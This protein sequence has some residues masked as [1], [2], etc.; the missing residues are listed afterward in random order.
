M[1][2]AP[3]SWFKGGLL[4]A[5][6]ALAGAAF[7]PLAPKPAVRVDAQMRAELVDGLARQLAA[8]YV[9]PDKGARM[10]DLIRA[11][12]GSGAYDA[13][14]D[15]DQLAAAVSADLQS[16]VR[17]LHLRVRASAEPVPTS[18]GI[19]AASGPPAKPSIL[20]RWM[21][22]SGVDQVKLLGANVGYLKLSSFAA[23]EQAGPRLAAAFDKLAGSSALIIDLR[24]NQ[25]GDPD[26]VALVAS[27]LFDRP[28]HL[29]DIWWR[30]SN[31]TT[32]Y[33]T[34][35]RVAGTR[36]GAHKRVFI[37]TSRR[38][39]SAAEEFAYDLKQLQ[40]ATIVGEPTWGGAHPARGYYAGR[41]F[42]AVIPSARA[43]NPVS[44]GNWEATGVLPD[45]A[46]PPEQALDY[47]LQELE[48]KHLAL[49]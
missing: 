18:L 8:H 41:H 15:A 27:Y 34:S 22:D 32:A 40:R 2:P 6:L 39:P 17:D 12:H 11:R 26:G 16:V 20:M 37:L 47:V 9:F 3:R 21:A 4:L 1:R 36:Y 13:L 5:A 31:T 24:D 49:N 28:T 42:I 44:R 10:G 30:D 33:W 48:N 23:P 35:A 29:N 38:T 25:G 14:S 7:L 43:I 19:P 45:F 46:V